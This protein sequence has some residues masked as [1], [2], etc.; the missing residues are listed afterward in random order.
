MAREFHW[1]DDIYFRA[2]DDGNVDVFKR[3]KLA[4]YWTHDKGFHDPEEIFFTVDGPSWA[5]ITMFIDT[6]LRNISGGD[7]EG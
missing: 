3:P 1:R 4:A 2:T 5:S 6:A 7:D